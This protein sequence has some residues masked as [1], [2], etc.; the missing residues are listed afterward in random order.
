MSLG[1]RGESPEVALRRSW[2]LEQLLEADLR[3]FETEVAPRS[4]ERLWEAEP[5]LPGSGPSAATN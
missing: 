4:E 2:V 5:R 3:I 1:E